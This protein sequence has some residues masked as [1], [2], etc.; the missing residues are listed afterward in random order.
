MSDLNNSSNDP[1]QPDDASDLNGHDITGDG[2]PLSDSVSY[3]PDHESDAMSGASRQLELV[4]GGHR[5]VFR[6]QPGLELKLLEDLQAMGRDPECPLSMFDAAVMSHQL[7][8]RMGR[9]F[10]ELLKA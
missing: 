8:L 1:L 9:R 5:Y 6:Y 7:G 2:W 4:K 3:S 10:E